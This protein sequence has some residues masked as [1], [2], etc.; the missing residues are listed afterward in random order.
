MTDHAAITA[1][2]IN[3]INPTQFPNMITIQRIVNQ[4]MELLQ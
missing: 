3:G 4:V 2:T 1:L